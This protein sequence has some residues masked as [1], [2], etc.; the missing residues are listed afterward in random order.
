MT[1]ILKS[2]VTPDG[3]DLQLEDLTDGLGGILQIRAG[4]GA[5]VRTIRDM[6]PHTMLRIF[7]KLLRGDYSVKDF[8][9]WSRRE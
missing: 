7:E 5:E 8:A 2:G 9:L 4:S 1:C 6:E 3:T